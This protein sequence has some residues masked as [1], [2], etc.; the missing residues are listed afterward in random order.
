MSL[1]GLEI[2]SAMAFT[3]S[4]NFTLT[5]IDVALSFVIG[6][7]SAMLSLNSDSGGLPD[8]V[9]ESWT[10]TGLPVFGTTSNTVQT[11]IPVSSVSLISGTQYWLVAS[12]IASN[13][14]DAWN[15]NSIGSNGLVTANLGGGFHPPSTDT[16]GAFD[17]LGTPAVPEPTS[18][19]LLATGLG[20]VVALRRHGFR[21]LK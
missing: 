12:T 1:V 2:E 18:I 13:T 21:S 7:N 8:G 16:Q 15:W 14:W 11:V 20:V 4:G 10:L 9:I 19:V 17:V 6:T 3:P 5:Q